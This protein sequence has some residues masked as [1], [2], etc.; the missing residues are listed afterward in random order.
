MDDFCGSKFWDLNLTWYTDDPDLTP[1]FQ[2]TVLVWTP[3]AFLW[4]FSILELYYLR[5]SQNKD[6]PWSF[7]NVSKLALIGLLVVLTVVDLVKALTTDESL[8]SGYPVYYYTPA[9]KIATF[10]F[11]GALVYLNKHYGMRTSGLL[12]LFWLLLTISSI[13]RVRTEIRQHEARE[14]S[15]AWKEYQFISF[16]IYFAITCVLFLLNFF[17]D[18]AP[19]VSKYEITKKDC[20]ELAASFPSRICFVCFFQRFVPVGEKSRRNFLG[21]ILGAHVPQVF[22]LERLPEANPC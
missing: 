21:R 5:K 8:G 12:F 22:H 6:V 13:P 18:K 1:C 14:L 17:V 9:I 15:H 20:P 2:Q 16:M 3:C 7:L 4:V 11:A 19:R 10:I